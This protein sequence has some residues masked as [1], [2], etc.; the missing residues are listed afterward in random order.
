MYQN[1]SVDSGQS[2]ESC[3][4]PFLTSH[5]IAVQRC[6]EVTPENLFSAIRL[7]RSVTGRITSV[8]SV[9]SE[10]VCVANSGMFRGRKEGRKGGRGLMVASK[11]PPLPATPG[12]DLVLPATSQNATMNHCYRIDSKSEMSSKRRKQRK[13]RED[14]SVGK[15]TPYATRSDR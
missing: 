7:Y 11:S 13:P 8:M 5:S 6:L 4:V 12:E 9:R 2:D 10:S 14:R 1:Q 3:K 15:G